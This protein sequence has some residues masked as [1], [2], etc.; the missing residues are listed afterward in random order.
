[1]DDP[2]KVNLVFHPDAF[3]FVCWRCQRCGKDCEYTG[4]ERRLDVLVCACGHR[5]KALVNGPDGS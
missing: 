4:R 2:V 3:V 1:M 5:F